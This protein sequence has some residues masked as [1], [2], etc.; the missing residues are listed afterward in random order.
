MYFGSINFVN[1]DGDIIYQHN[2]QPLLVMPTGGDPGST[3]SELYEI[4][5]Y[6]AAVAYTDQSLPD[7]TQTPILPQKIQIGTLGNLDTNGTL[8]VALPKHTP[9]PVTPQVNGSKYYLARVNAQPY[10]LVSQC[11]ASTPTNRARTTVGVGEAVN[12][13]FQPSLPI[14]VNWTV[15]AGS[16][17]STSG[18]STWFVAPS[19]AAT[20]TITITASI[21]R[22]S[23][24]IPFTVVAPSGVSATITSTRKQNIPVGV[25]GAYM[26]LNVTM[27]PTNVSFYR[28]SMLEVTNAATSVTGY[29]TSHWPSPHDNVA[30]AGQWHPVGVDNL[31]DVANGMD[32]CSYYGSSHLPPPWSPGGSFTWPIPGQWKIGNG[33]TNSLS[34]SDQVFTLGAN[35]TFTITKFGQSVTRTVNNVITPNLP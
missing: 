6:A 2:D 30:G 22:Q 17:T 13:F 15:S 7:A 20:T 16:L 5:G 4:S 24:S 1:S 9:V 25:A 11:W 18:P 33:S 26:H 21:G 10:K 31:I 14:N 12:V 3:G 19:N 23:V 27:Q 8:W 35:G 34:W 28:V 29:F 32:T